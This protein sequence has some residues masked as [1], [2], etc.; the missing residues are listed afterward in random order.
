MVQRISAKSAA[1]DS[2]HASRS[3]YINPVNCH[4]ALAQPFKA[5]TLAGA[6]SEVLA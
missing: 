4:A 3:Y 2:T 5:V 6:F 1:A